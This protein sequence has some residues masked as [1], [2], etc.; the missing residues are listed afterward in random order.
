M[1]LHQR[2]AVPPLGSL[3]ESTS[4]LAANFV[5]VLS[6]SLARSIGANEPSR[7]LERPADCRQRKQRPIARRLAP[8][9]NN[10]EANRC[11]IVRC[12]S[13]GPTLCGCWLAASI[14]AICH[15]RATKPN[16]CVRV[17]TLESWLPSG[18]FR[19]A[20]QGSQRQMKPGRIQS[21]RLL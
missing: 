10:R 13:N 9:E 19:G 4:R 5:P 6:R 12:A 3:S 8:S 2:R 7:R 11:A 1:V 14:S 15:A 17:R 16:A 20:L 18:S 21:S